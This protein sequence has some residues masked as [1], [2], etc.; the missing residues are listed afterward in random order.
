MTPE[1]D[2]GSS[3]VGSCA[4]VDGLDLYYERHG[5]GAPL[6]LLHGAFGTIESCFARLL[7]ILAVER[8]V[9]AVELQGHGHTAD[10]DR[11][12]TYEH[13]AEDVAALLEILNIERADV[14]GYSMGGAVG[15]QLAM[16]NPAVVRRLVFAGGASY[17]PSGYYPEFLEVLGTTSV[18]DLAGSHWERAHLD[19]APHADQWPE[20]V[21]KVNALDRDFRGWS[22]DDVRAVRAPT[23]LING[24]SDI[25]QPEHAVAMFRL[26][27]GGAPADLTSAPDSRLAVL[28]G[29]SHVSLLERVDWLGIMIL[30]F[31]NAE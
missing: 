26:L 20:L 4:P 9:I 25:I 13:M 5:D 21:A 28:P 14:V 10:I 16:S 1:H 30:E 29:T 15:L 19:V 24:D 23:L 27:G 2:A 22:A 7:P 31:L 6:V 17:D 3:T 18:D 11:P 12:L 8:H